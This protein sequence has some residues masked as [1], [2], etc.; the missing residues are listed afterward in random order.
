LDGK[1]EEAEKMMELGGEYASI[2][3][4]LTRAMMEWKKV[5]K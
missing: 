1:K 4:K 5:S 2:S 3:G